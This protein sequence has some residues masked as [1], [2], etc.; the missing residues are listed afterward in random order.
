MLELC[1]NLIDNACKWAEHDVI[2]TVQETPEWQL[3]V[4]DDGPGCSPTC[5]VKCANA[6]GDSMKDRWPW[7][8]AIDR[9]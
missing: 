5:G 2:V 8:G 4:E 9:A 3:T 7:A 6:A 1:G